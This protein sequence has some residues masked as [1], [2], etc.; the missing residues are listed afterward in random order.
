[1]FAHRGGRTL[2]PENTIEAFD[3]GLAAGAEGL[4]LDVHLSADG[5]AVVHHD[6]D[7][8]RCTDHRGPLCAL[9]AAALAAVD[10]AW[11]FDEGS[12]FPLRGR[13]IGVPAL[14][15]VLSRYPAIPVIVEIKAPTAETARAVVET[16]RA[17]RALDRVCVGSFSQTALD[18]VRALEP[19]LAT[20]ASREESQRALY[21]SWCGVAIRR[22]PPYRAFQVPEQ[23]GRLTVVSPRFIR[24]VHRR[25]VPIQ[26]WTVNEEADMRRLLDWGVD[27][28]IT[29]RPDLAVAVRDAWV[30]ARC[31]DRS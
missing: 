18:A 11:S 20:S 22:R 3:R 13:G 4:E 30:R 26:V 24:A 9:T 16:L 31:E 6:P 2:G 23:A 19:R 17:A 28:L 25:H 10:A 5:V 15:D 8:D 12:G 21:R 7:L 27:G 14:A 29:D 1:V